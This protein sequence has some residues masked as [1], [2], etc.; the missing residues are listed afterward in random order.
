MTIVIIIILWGNTKMLIFRKPM[1]KVK[2]AVDVS[3]CQVE[4]VDEFRLLGVILDNKLTFVSHI[5]SVLSSCARRLYLLKMLRDQG[6][7][8]SCLHTIFFSL[9]VNKVTYCISAWRG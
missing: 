5:T 9:I 8:I 3:G 1:R 2:L 6:M 4:Q 7:P